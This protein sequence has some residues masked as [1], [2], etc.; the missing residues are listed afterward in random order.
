MFG[1]VLQQMASYSI[2]METIKRDL[3]NCREVLT[4]KKLDLRRLWIRSLH[5][6]QSLK[7]LD[8][9]YV[10]FHSPS[11]PTNPLYP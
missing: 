9:M 1:E 7:L 6:S 8:K 11:I 4:P 3:L 5:Y 10:C 2:K